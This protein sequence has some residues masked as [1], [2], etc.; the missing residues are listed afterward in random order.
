MHRG[1]VKNPAL[2]HI[3]IRGKNE[4]KKINATALPTFGTGANANSKILQNFDLF[5]SLTAAHPHSDRKVTKTFTVVNRGGDQFG[6][7]PL[8]IYRD[9]HLS[10]PKPGSDE[11]K[12]YNLYPVK[13]YTE[14]NQLKFQLPPY[15]V[16]R[17][18]ISGDEISTRRNCKDCAIGPYNSSGIRDRPGI[19]YEIEYKD[20]EA[21]GDDKCCWEW[22]DVPESEC[23]N[24]KLRDVNEYRTNKNY[25][26]V[27]YGDRVRILFINT[28]SFEGSEGHPMHLH[29]HDFTLT[30]LYNV[31]GDTLTDKNPRKL[32]A[33][34]NPTFRI[35]GPK[36][37][38]IWVPYNQAVAF[39][40]DAYNAG[41]HLFHCHND[42]H[43]ENG[44]MT[45]IRYMHDD[46]CANNL[47]NFTGGTN[48]YPQQFCSM[49]NCSPESE[50]L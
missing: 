5:E 17:N 46:T 20:S 11:D 27:C 49:D 36:V 1:N 10:V 2:R 16:Y 24:F 42:F 14:L 43:L 47:P 44:M 35:T 32:Q 6:G 7:F 28:A 38:T 25:I 21:Q 37:D 33:L 34:E 9:Q 48:E 41:E 31:T 30:A 3:V 22:C 15:K 19:D 8:S 12:R 45:T 40:F 29:G 18:E 50:E 39:E 23:E 26:P 4:D 13:N